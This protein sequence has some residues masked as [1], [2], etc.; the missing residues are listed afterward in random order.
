M[1]VSTAFITALMLAILVAGVAVTY[2]LTNNQP[3][4]TTMTTTP[5]VTQ[6]RNQIQQPTNYGEPLKEVINRISELKTEVY[7]VLLAKYYVLSAKHL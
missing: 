5:T 4:T 3:L 2:A 1:R 6:G 7:D